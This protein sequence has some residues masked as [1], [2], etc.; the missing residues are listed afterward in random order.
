MTGD[1]PRPRWSRIGSFVPAHPR[2]AARLPRARLHRPTRASGAPARVTE[3]APGRGRRAPLR[4]RPRTRGRL[5]RADPAGARDAAR[6]LGAPPPHGSPR[7][8]P[9]RGR[10]RRRALARERRPHLPRRLLLLAA[11][12]VRPRR[13]RPGRAPP[14]RVRAPR[15]RPHPLPVPPRGEQP[16]VR[17]AHAAR[18]E[19]GAE[20]QLRDRRRRGGALLAQGVGR[21]AA[22]ARLRRHAA[23]RRERVP[24]H[25]VERA[26]RG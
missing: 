13:L 7:P 25:R 14:D 20:R 17:D 9:A 4:R 15:R 26:R 19:A 1:A 23:A 6:G 16:G 3:R 11:E 10:A 2:P 24:R 5:S 12:R 21:R 18:G 8:G 22:R